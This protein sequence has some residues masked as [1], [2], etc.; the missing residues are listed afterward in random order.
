MLAAAAVIAAADL[1]LRLLDPPYVVAGLLDEPAHLA[2]TALVH[3]AW[4]GTLPLPA[5][6]AALAASVLIDVDHLPAVLGSDAVLAGAPRPYS[7]SLFTPIVLLGL[8]ALTRGSWRALLGGG[9]LGVA[10]H[11]LRDLAGEPGVPLAWP[12]STA[13]VS[14]P[15]ALEVAVVGGLA[16]RAWTVR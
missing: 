4:P 11:L 10:C 15:L 3:A 16:A 12:L 14:L 9:A 13:A 5:V 6:L 7:H 2:T 1:A 8:A